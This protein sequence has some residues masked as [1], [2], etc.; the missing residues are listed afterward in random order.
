MF[1]WKTCRFIADNKIY[2][3]KEIVEDPKGPNTINTCSDKLI[4]QTNLYMYHNHSDPY[5]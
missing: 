4:E 2:K 3:R 1:S 5:S